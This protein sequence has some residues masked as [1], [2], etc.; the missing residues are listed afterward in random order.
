M[1]EDDNL[2]SGAVNNDAVSHGYKSMRQSEDG[3]SSYS[4]NKSFRASSPM[5]KNADSSFVN[6][7][8]SALKKPTDSRTEKTGSVYGISEAGGRS[9]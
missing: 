7:L 8:H 9:T 3:K 4:P 2:S 6:A 1:D 5:R